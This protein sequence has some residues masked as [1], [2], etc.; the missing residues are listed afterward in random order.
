MKIVFAAALLLAISAESKPEIAPKYFAHTR[1]IKQSDPA[2]QPYIVIDEQ[3]WNGSEND[4]DDLRIYDGQQEVP[5]TLVMEHAKS[6]SVDTPARILNKGAAAAKTEFVIESPID[7]FDTLVLDLKTK[8][9]TTRASVSGADELPSKNWADLGSFTLFDFTKEQLG[10]NTSI[11]LKSPV[12]YKYLRIQLVDSVKPEDVLSAGIANRQTEK[13]KYTDWSQKPSIKQEQRTTI[14]EWAGSKRVPLEHIQFEVEPSEINFSRPVTLF[15]ER[16]DERSASFGKAKSHFDAN[17]RGE[18]SK[19][20]LQ[21][22]QHVVEYESLELTPGSLHC[23]NY[24]LE[25][26]NGD[27]QAVKLTAVRPQ[28]NERRVYWKPG[29]TAPKLYYGDKK[30][31]AAQYDFAKFFDEPQEA[32]AAQLGPEAAN[33]DHTARADDRPW[34]ERNPQ[35]M[36]AAMIIAV[37]GLGAWA[38]KGFKA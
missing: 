1:E 34:S 15:C 14:I 24:R 3:I 28:S 16:D 32:T 5:F 26:V 31:E 35:L 11:K 38:L 7:E 37:L 21:R 22:K 13:A 19:V 23:T 2:K 18:I 10:H 36:W 12:R 20:K 8:D 25:I 33:Q 30:V 29:A 6:S 4:L 9:F 17:T 27:D